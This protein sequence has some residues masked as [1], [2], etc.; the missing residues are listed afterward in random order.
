MRDIP[1]RPAA[2]DLSDD[3]IEQVLGVTV[4]EPEPAVGEMGDPEWLKAVCEELRAIGDIMLHA[5]GRLDAITEILKRR[6]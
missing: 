2:R 4:A 5:H 1:A 6:V 3:A